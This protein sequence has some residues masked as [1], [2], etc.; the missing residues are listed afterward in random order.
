MN[1]KIKN[2]AEWIWQLPQNICGIV[3][4]NIK[5]DSI[6][7]EVGNSIASSVNAKVYL[8]RA[9]GGVTLGK[10]IFI[11]QT[12]QDQGK[13]IKH[14]CG[15]VKQSKMLG[16]LYLIVIGVPSILH[17]WLN[18]Y[19]G[20]DKKHKEGYYHFY[21]EHILMGEFDIRNQKWAI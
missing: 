18:D 16:P 12:Y 7:T 17:A 6:I 21:T 13:V 5:K 9:G 20:C 8:M 10:Y 11:S 3:W 19:I 15:H 1:G 14:E 4:R 2:I